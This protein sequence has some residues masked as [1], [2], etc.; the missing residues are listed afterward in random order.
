M[1]DSLQSISIFLLLGLIIFGIARNYTKTTEIAVSRANVLIEQP[2]T[3]QVQPAAPPPPP[4][5]LTNEP[6]YWHP[7]QVGPHWNSR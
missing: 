7:I 1:K 3:T 6:M 4:S 2:I 5:S